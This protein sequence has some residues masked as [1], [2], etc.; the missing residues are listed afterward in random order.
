MWG[1]RAHRAEWSWRFDPGPG[2]P[3][4]PLG[5]TNKAWRRATSIV[6]S[7]GW[8]DGWW[9]AAAGL[10]L[11]GS[12]WLAAAWLLPTAGLSCAA[13][14]LTGRMAPVVAVGVVATAWVLVIAPTTIA[15]RLDLAFGIAAQVF[16]LAM[17]IGGGLWLAVARNTVTIK[18]GRSA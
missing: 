14:V 4:A 11:P 2:E 12:D 5:T 6:G 7:R 18:L 8:H 13:L 17:A 3:F 16:W 1:I 10:A 9:P 15:G